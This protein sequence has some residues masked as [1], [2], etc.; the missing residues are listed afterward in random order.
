MREAISSRPALISCLVY[1]FIIILTIR[2]MSSTF[3]Q[4]TNSKYWKPQNQESSS[5]V[6]KYLMSWLIKFKQDEIT[7]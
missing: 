7:R 2:F 4:I 5:S 1:T 6:H 3:V